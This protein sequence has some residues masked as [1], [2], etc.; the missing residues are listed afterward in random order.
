MSENYQHLNIEEK[1]SVLII[2]I[3]RESSLNALNIKTVEE[4]QKEFSLRH[5][6]KNI[7]CIIIT[8]RGDKAFI[9]G[10]DI[11]EMADLD[12]ESS[13]QFSENG[14]ALMDMI[15][16]CPIPVIAAIN[17]FALGG[18]CELALACDIR[19]ASEKAKL[20]QPEVNLGLLPGYGGTQRLP[21]LVGRGKAM[22]LI[23][24]AALIS[25]DE[26]HR[27]GLVDE[28]YPHD[29]LMDKAISMAELICS[30][31]PLAV[32]RSKDSVNRG[33]DTDMTSGC[34]IEKENFASVFGSEDKNEGVTAFLEKRKPKFVGK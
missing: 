21:R 14:H 4:L 6:D 34:N 17:G 9:A 16:N 32:R 31:A 18:G 19:L 5:D 12:E 2:R 25:A 10:A 3:D 24:T 23:L 1:G 22:Q 30:K 33:I 27:I 11:S 8:G 26:A 28:V 29:E 13:R 7:H 20:G 15:Q